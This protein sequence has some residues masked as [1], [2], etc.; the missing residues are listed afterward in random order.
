MPR[1]YRPRE[2]IRVLEYLGWNHARTRGSHARYTSPDGRRH[3]TVD[4]AIRELAPK[5]FSSVLKQA[6]LSRNE[7][8]R[9]A[10]EV[11]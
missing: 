6:G 11:L 5:L 2:I 8:E 3:V 7:F 4:L 9:L 10:E 1:R